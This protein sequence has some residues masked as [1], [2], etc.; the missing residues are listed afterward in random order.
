MVP[1][2]SNTM[3]EAPAPAVQ[4][5]PTYVWW[6]RERWRL[7]LVLIATSA[8]MAGASAPSPFYPVIQADFGFAPVMIT[9][10]FA[11]YAVALLA[12]LLTAGAL[13]DH[14]GRRP[15]ICAAF[16]VLA[17]SMFLF[18]HADSAATLILSRVVQGIA[19]GILLSTLSA[20][21][22]DLEL[23][24]KPGSAS[25]W[26]AISAMAGLAIGG[27]FAGATLA[28]FV[29]GN[30]AAVVFGTLVAT[31]L[32]L[33][34]IIWILPETSARRRGA[35][36]SLLPRAALPREVRKAFLFAVPA[37]IAGWA[38][39]G[40]YLSLGANI[41]TSE[42]HSSSHLV[43][44]LIVTMLAG[45]GGLAG[46]FMRNRS[47]RTVTLY[48]TISLAVG[49]TLTLVALTLT[50][51]ELYCLAVIITGTGFGTAF[52]GALKTIQAVVKPEA[53]AEVMAAVFVVCYLA[54]GLPVVIAGV[55]VPAIGLFA[56]ACWYGGFVA[57]LALC[58]ALLRW[59]SGGGRHFADTQSA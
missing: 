13:S 42:F 35:W 32:L 31:Y 55:L 28:V 17:I 20:T 43:S 41:I 15:V 51:P 48:G 5:A 37:F 49:S 12:A 58:A 25:S 29:D 44:G 3:E 52:P 39:G 50:S 24:H 45:A 11:A 23:P 34:G 53:N 36:A 46:F 10:V 19:S 57:L 54:F 26:N 1:K 30:G 16:V 8:M 33:A 14:I 21:V 4:P 47:A 40:L 22:V 7:R 9:V 27:L 38:T 18:W 6:S 59:F 56:T 2:V